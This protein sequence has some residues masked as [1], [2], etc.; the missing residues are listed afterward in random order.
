MLPGLLSWCT[1]RPHGHG[2]SSP[3]P[4]LLPHTCGRRDPKS[5]PDHR[6]RG[7]F[8]ATGHLPRSPPVDGFLVVAARK[9]PRAPGRIAPG[10]HTPYR[11]QDPTT[12]TT[13]APPPSRSPPQQH[14]T[15]STDEA[16]PAD[17]HHP[18]APQRRR[19]PPARTKSSA[20][21]EE[22]EPDHTCGIEMHCGH[23]RARND[24]RDRPLC[25]NTHR[26]ESS[27]NLPCVPVS[28]AQYSPCAAGQLLRCL[29]QSGSHAAPARHADR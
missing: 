26:D 14:S 11:L 29:S 12:E 15:P 3:A 20:D 9:P 1:P 13:P 19:A 6:R 17:E 27:Q 2:K 8:R 4:L 25:G 21:E 10:G 18:P 23:I 24:L 7:T 22:T 16:A 5:P 28:A